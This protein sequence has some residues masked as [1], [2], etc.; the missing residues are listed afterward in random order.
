M[1]FEGNGL[2]VVG[3]VTFNNKEQIGF[4]VPVE[5]FR[6]SADI[7][8]EDNSDI[9]TLNTKAQKLAPAFEFGLRPNVLQFDA[10]TRKYGDCAAV[11]EEGVTQGVKTTADK[12]L[13][14]PKVGFNQINKHDFNSETLFP[15]VALW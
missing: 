1:G 13:A 14:D 3:N 2:Q 4:K 15:T 12:M 9:L 8:A 6:L 11:V 10:D 7:V 5:S